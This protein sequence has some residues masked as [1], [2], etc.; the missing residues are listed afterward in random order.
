[1]D[2]EVAGLEQGGGG[3]VA[4]H[5]Q[6]D[7][8]AL[9]VAQA[10]GNRQAAPHMA[11]AQAGPAIAADQGREGPVLDRFLADMAIDREQVRAPAQQRQ[12][13]DHVGVRGGDTKG[14]VKRFHEGEIVGGIDAEPRAGDP[15]ILGQGQGRR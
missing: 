1:M 11:Q 12:D 10:L 8:G 13:F 3:I 4:R 15:A 6:L 9:F 5:G 7:H 2:T 14:A